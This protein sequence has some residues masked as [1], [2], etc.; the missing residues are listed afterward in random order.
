M[1]ILICTSELA[2]YAKAGGLADVMRSLAVA[3][4]RNGINVKIFVPKY[5][6]VVSESGSVFIDENVEVHFVKN[7]K[8]FNRDCIYGDANGDYQDNLKRFS[9]FCSETLRLIKKMN[10]KPDIIHCHD[11]QT[12]LIPF[13]LETMAKKD[14]FYQGIKTLLM[15]NNVKYQGIFSS[16]NIE[17]PDLRDLL[18]TKGFLENDKS[19][20]LLKLAISTA[21]FISTVSPAYE[22]EIQTPKMGYGLEEI[23][24]KRKNS[25]HGI[26]NGIDYGAW[27]PATDPYISVQYSKENLDRKVLNK[28][29]LQKQLNFFENKSIPLLGIVT[30]LVDQKGIDLVVSTLDKMLRRGVQFVLLGDGDSKYKEILRNKQI[31]HIYNTSMNFG[32][33]PVL[34]QKIYAGCDMFLMPSKYE[35]CGSSQMI[36]LRYGTI[37]IVRETGGLACTVIDY[38]RDEIRGNGFVFNDYTPE[39]LFD[40]F[41][42]ALFAYENKNIWMKLQKNAMNTD[43]SWESSGLEYIKLYKEI[44]QMD[45]AKING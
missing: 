44:V 33:D 31:E 37:P 6:S 27:D 45:V 14:S 30:R 10:Y 43:Y 2:G 1:N 9:F 35:P 21:S 17:V 29:A 40:A 19:V 13:L 23:L 38:N 18:E 25:L 42:R 8:Y 24:R 36:S 39:A 22:K 15:I 5:K 12:G 4:G 26:V 16:D 20:N 41:R 11:W 3:V 7:D 32:Y 34:A 28:I